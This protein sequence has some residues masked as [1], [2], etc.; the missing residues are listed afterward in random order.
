MR[1]GQAGPALG[2][3]RLGRSSNCS[4]SFPTK[5]RCGS[6]YRALLAQRHKPPPRGSRTSS[7]LTEQVHNSK[8]QAASLRRGADLVPIFTPSRRRSAMATVA[9]LARRCAKCMT[10]SR[11]RHWS[12]RANHDTKPD[13]QNRIDPFQSKTPAGRSRARR[14]GLGPFSSCRRRPVRNSRRAA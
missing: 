6:N 12:G 2:L 8:I 14:T 7:V 10:R 4:S 13:D 11:L 9:S 3:G 5:G 1:A